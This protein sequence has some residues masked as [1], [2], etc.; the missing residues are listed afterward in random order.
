MTVNSQSI[1]RLTGD[2]IPE[3]VEMMVRAF[4]DYPLGN[5]FSPDPAQRKNAPPYSSFRSVARYGLYY[6]EIYATSA[7]LEGAAVWVPSERLPRTWWR[8]LRCGDIMQFLRM[9]R[10]VRTRTQAFDKH[11]R[12]MHQRYA[13]FPHLYLQMLG[14]DPDH[15]GKGYSSLLLRHMFAR[16]DDVPLPCYLETHTEQNVAIYEHLGFKVAEARKIPDS[17]ITT[18]AMLRDNR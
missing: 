17:G 10:E 6:G 16:I 1:V 8:S 13:P 5:Y 7:D 3:L 18:W 11:T 9:N 12:D 4:R 15:R 2:S 14:V